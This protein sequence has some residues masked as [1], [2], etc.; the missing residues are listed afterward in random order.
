MPGLCWGGDGA[1]DV[2][3]EPLCLQCLIGEGRLQRIV[4]WFKKSWVPSK[5]E[6]QVLLLIEGMWIPEGQMGQKIF[7]RRD[8]RIP[9][10][11]QE[12]PFRAEAEDSRPAGKRLCAPV[13]D[14]AGPQALPP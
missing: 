14:C 10:Q 4:W 9:E 8:G 1:G 3:H 2:G 13:Y 11:G 12:G 7:E 6:N 5:G